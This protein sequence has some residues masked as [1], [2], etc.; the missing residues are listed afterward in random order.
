MTSK[1]INYTLQWLIEESEREERIKYLF[2]WGHQKSKDGSLTSSC[3]SQWWGSPFEVDGMIYRT[4]EHWMMAQKALLFGDKVIFEKII[5]SK[6]PGEA[7]ELGRQVKN[8]E[9]DIWNKHRLDIVVNGNLHKFGQDSNLKAFLL[10]TKDRVLV[11]ASPVD[12]IWGI[13]LSADNKDRENPRLWKGINLLGFSLM[14]VRD[15]LMKNV[16]INSYQQ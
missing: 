12:N 9:E 16:K 14:T 3:F 10:S 11:E 13:G 6:S 8:F 4:A 5:K 15:I 7:K 1:K 2:F